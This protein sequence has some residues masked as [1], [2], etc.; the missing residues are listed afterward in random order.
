MKIPMSRP[1]IGELEVAKV[2]EVLRSSTLSRG[3]M[4]A[5][6]ERELARFVGVEHAVAVSSGTAGLHLAVRAAGVSVRDEVIT[7]PFSFVA[8]ANCILYEGARPVFVDIDRQTLNLDPKLIEERVTNRTVAILP[9]H[10][11]GQPCE[12]DTIL[13]I[14]ERNHLMVIEDA[15]E[16]LGAEFDGRKVGTFGDLGTYAFYPNKQLTTGEGGMVVTSDPERA[17]LLRSLRNQGRDSDECL[18]SSRLGYNY[19]ID[20]L[21]SA[22]GVAQLERVEELLAKRERV[23]RWYTERLGTTNTIRIPDP[24]PRTTISWFVYVI[25]LHEG[26][27][28]EAV[29]IQLADQG[30]PSRSYFSPIH[31]LPWIREA[32]G[33]H[34]GECPVAEAVSRSTLA[35]P[36]HGN[37]REAE[38][39][40][41]CS[42]LLE[43]VS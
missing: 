34:T 31:L 1:D 16:S 20:E 21:S 38:V 40:H 5:A 7:T 12:M 23:A 24:A 14:A 6:F 22:L 37:M 43:A 8:S 36:F 30:I 10:V 17:A 13:Q 19:R 26:I 33:P 42:V 3:P 4:V 9:V 39:S 15:C 29:Q 32:L 25:R 28:R 2:T 41:V 18:T 11:F 27:D 35:L